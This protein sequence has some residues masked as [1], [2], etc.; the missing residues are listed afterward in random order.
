MEETVKSFK[1][2]LAKMHAYQ[3]AISTLHYDAETVMP[4]KG[5]A[6]FSQTMGVLSE[7]SY[8]LSTGD[9]MRDL[10]A[11]LAPKKDA[12]DEIT[13]REAEELGEQLEKLAR[14]PSRSTSNI[15]WI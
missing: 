13:R 10:L 7:E 5:A 1:A 8:K 12:L 6:D 14:I 11:K 3:H 4:K 15:P 2:L 9:E